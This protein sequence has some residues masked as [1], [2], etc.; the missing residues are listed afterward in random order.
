[1]LS[2]NWRFLT[3]S[4]LVVFLGGGG[5]QKWP[6]LCRKRTTKRGQ[7]VKNRQFWDNIVYGP[8]WYVFY[9]QFI[10][11]NKDFSSSLVWL[12]EKSF[13]KPLT[14]LLCFCTQRK[15]LFHI[16]ANGFERGLE[17]HFSIL[18]IDHRSRPLG[19]WDQAG[20][21]SHLRNLRFLQH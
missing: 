15:F 6:I 4:P 18:I 7:G 9:T 11:Y 19:H 17:A 16:V 5:R 10:L 8:Y 12:V 3:P 14:L 2:Q 1:M 21:L 13:Y 20:V